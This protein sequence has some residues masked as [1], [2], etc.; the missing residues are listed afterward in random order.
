[1]AVTESSIF[2]A[3]RQTIHFIVKMRDQPS[4][5][6]SMISRSSAA[7][8]DSKKPCDPS[9][10]LS[11][12]SFLETNSSLSPS[13]SGSSFKSLKIVSSTTL[14]DGSNH[15][16]PKLSTLRLLTAHFGA[17]LALFLATTDA[18]IVS[19]S[20]P[21][22]ASELEAS[23]IQYTWVG[24]AYMLTQTAFQPLYGRISDLVGRK[25]ILY[26]SMAIFALGSLLCG[27]SQTITWLVSARALAGIGGGG[28]VSSVWV[29]TAEIV[30]VEHRAKWSQALS[31]TWSCS[32]IAGPLL[33]GVFSGR[34]GLDA[35]SWRWGFYLNLPICLVAFVVLLISLR[36]ISF[37]KSDNVS[38]RSLALNFDFG[39]LVLFMSGTSCIVVGFS[40][41]T[42]CGWTAPST[43]SLISLGIVILVCGGV[44]ETYTTRDCLFP[45]STFKNITAVI[46][47]FVTFLHNFAFNAGTFYLAL[48]YQA[49]NGS[50]P[51]EAG[52]KLLPYSLGSSLASMPAAWFIG[53]WQRRTLDTSG[54]LWTISCGLLISTLGFALLT[55]LTEYASVTSQ[56]L[57]SLIAGIGLGML[58]HAPYQVFTRALKPSELAT[59]TSAFFLVRFTGATI[60]LAVAGA[61]FY[62]R[63]SGRL[64]PDLPS[65]ISGSS[66]D[67]SLLRSIQP[68]ALRWQVLHIV[69]SSIQTIWIVCAPC[70]GIAFLVSLC[71]RKTSVGR[72]PAAIDNQKSNTVQTSAEVKI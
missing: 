32:A 9:R 70:L 19:T 20:L 25:T 8:G 47:L 48:Y 66:I 15:R 11:T 41:A 2:K 58:F 33:G 21:T 23:Q 50:T 67:Y 62:A 42:D 38:W 49:A 56:I 37:G 4:R 55:L 54:Q 68:L 6:P 57:Y 45:P 14:D 22:I 52:I 12:P 65:Q 5:D 61:V 36:G 16:S 24:V 35:L 31:V 39:G 10:S 59:G 29:I 34:N 13:S 46:I 3:L 53:Y 30:E 26:S 71:L 40:F 72:H 43:L 17:A 18:T 1:M 44:Y 7:S 64:P 28:I 63:A 27:A 51:L 69:S 60:G